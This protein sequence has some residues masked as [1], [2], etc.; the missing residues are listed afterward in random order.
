MH[1]TSKRLRQDSENNLKTESLL[2]P[3][4]FEQEGRGIRDSALHTQKH[5]SFFLEECIK[6]FQFGNAPLRMR[7]L[8]KAARSLLEKPTP[9]ALWST[10]SRWETASNLNPAL[11]QREGQRVDF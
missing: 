11:A 6:S 7:S 2:L 4:S 1:S 3:G 10:F 5:L 9:T 8:A